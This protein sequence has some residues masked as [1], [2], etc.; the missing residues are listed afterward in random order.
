LPLRAPKPYGARYWQNTG[1]DPSKSLRDFV[2]YVFGQRFRYEM[3]ALSWRQQVRR[4]GEWLSLGVQQY[5]AL[6]GMG[7]ALGWLLVR[8]QSAFWFVTLG[9]GLAH[10]A[11]YLSYDVPDIAYFFIPAWSLVV[12]WG[13]LVAHRL[14]ALVARASS[15]AGA[16]RFGLGVQ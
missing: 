10:M 15:F 4:F 14:W 11:F 5:G 3:G 2:R 7:I 13:G 1:D 12:L 16:D 6:F 8:A 9:M